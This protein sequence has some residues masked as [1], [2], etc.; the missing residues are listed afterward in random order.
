MLSILSLKH[1][2]RAKIL[3]TMRR[4]GGVG[5]G[6]LV[7]IHVDDIYRIAVTCCIYFI[8]RYQAVLG[9]V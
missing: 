8:A 9:R 2:L 6:Q 1:A 5:A 4:L 7:P 3:S